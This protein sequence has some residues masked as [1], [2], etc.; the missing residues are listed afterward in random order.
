MSVSS[1]FF[2][3]EYQTDHV[4]ST[5]FLCLLYSDHALLLK[6]STNT[7][8]RYQIQKKREQK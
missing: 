6:F 2:D 8:Q 5:L 7:Y 3:E 1:N 4:M